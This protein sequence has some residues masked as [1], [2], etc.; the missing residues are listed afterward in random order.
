[1][2]SDTLDIHKSNMKEKNCADYSSNFDFH[3]SFSKLSNYN[4]RFKNRTMI[5]DKFSE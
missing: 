3:S 4:R 2:G 1:M 5:D